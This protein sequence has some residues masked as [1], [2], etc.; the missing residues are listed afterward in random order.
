MKD[1]LGASEST[2]AVH[3]GF[4]GTA[5][6]VCV[7]KAAASADIRK[8]LDICGQVVATAQEEYLSC[9]ENRCSQDYLVGF[10]HVQKAFSLMFSSTYNI[11]D[12]SLHHQLVLLSVYLLE[13]EATAP[14]E[15]EVF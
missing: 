1:C 12:L 13:K 11:S 5:L 7:K 3:K 9:K 10:Q 8:A 6:E 14:S 15:L 2:E 4:N